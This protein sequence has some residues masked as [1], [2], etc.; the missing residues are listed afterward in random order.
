MIEWLM[1]NAGVTNGILLGFTVVCGLALLFSS[2]ALRMSRG[3]LQQS[4]AF[5]Q[6]YLDGELIGEPCTPTPNA[7]EGD[8]K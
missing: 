4:T 2:W 7:D 1:A 6:A 3:R 8:G 5:Y